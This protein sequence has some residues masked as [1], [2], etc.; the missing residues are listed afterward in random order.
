[1]RTC[2]G[3]RKVVPQRDLVRVAFDQSRLKVDRPRPSAARW[4]RL[5]GRGAYVHATAACVTAS[6]LARSL[7]RAVTP[8]DVQRIVT[9]L[10]RPD[11][12]SNEIAPSGRDPGENPHDLNPGLATTKP[13]ETTSSDHC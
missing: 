5:P 7:R 11:D 9:E 10:S 13:V 3:C 6:G 2:T 12:N 8:D 1:M 4:R